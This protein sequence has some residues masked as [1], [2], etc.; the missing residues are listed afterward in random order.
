M[1]KPTNLQ[2]NI[3][4]E[5]KGERV[6]LFQPITTWFM[7]KDTEQYNEHNGQNEF[8]EHHEYGEQNGQGDL[9]QSIDPLDNNKKKERNIKFL[10][11]SKNANRL[12][13]LLLLLLL[14]IIICNL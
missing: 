5:Y 6:A 8:I 13:Q 10:R 9:Q 2:E 1:N 3:W 4:D 14:I 11:I 7:H 12:L